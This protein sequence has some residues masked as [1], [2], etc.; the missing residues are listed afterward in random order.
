MQYSF[1]ANVPSPALQAFK[2]RTVAGPSSVHTTVIVIYDPSTACVYIAYQQPLQASIY[3]RHPLQLSYA[4][5]YLQSPIVTI[6][7][8]PILIA[9]IQLDSSPQ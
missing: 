1:Q 2:L 4:M 5:D 8:N 3:I 6:L 7:T 9:P